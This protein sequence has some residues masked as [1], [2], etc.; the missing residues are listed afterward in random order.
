[1]F[2]FLLII[3]ATFSASIHK[4]DAPQLLR[5]GEGAGE[6]QSPNY[7]RRYPNN[8]NQTWDLEVAADQKIKL[9]FDS[10]DLEDASSCRYDYVQISHGS[11]EEKYCGFRK[12]DPIISSGNT[13]TVTF[14][15]DYSVSRYGF[16]AT[17]EAVGNSVSKI[18]SPNYPGLYP[19]NL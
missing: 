12:P 16:K 5:D 13:M 15:S 1:M 14:Y 19:H 11:F 9:S 10:F 17:W 2:V 4:E 6:L 18:Q 3:T 7:P 8:Q